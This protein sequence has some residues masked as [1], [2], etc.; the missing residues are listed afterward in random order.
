MWLKRAS[1]DKTFYVASGTWQAVFQW[2]TNE[3]QVDE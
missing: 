1:K 2:R 3:K